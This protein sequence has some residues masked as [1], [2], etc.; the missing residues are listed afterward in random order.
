MVSLNPNIERWIKASVG[1]HL[2]DRKGDYEL[3]LEGQIKNTQD[4]QVWAE[5]KII[6][7]THERFSPNQIR[8]S[9]TIIIFTNTIIGVEDQQ[10]HTRISGHFL[11]LFD[12]PINIYRFGDGVMDDKQWIGC[13]ILR[14]DVTRPVDRLDYGNI[15]N[16]QMTSLEGQYQMEQP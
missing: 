7:L 6:G 11:S 2:V 14:S 1:R 16:V 8:Y 12:G 15:E 13:L 4:L 3:F 5:A 9:C 10:L